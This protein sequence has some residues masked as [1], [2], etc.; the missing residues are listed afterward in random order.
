MHSVLFRIREPVQFWWLDQVKIDHKPHIKNKLYLEQLDVLERYACLQSYSKL[1]LM[2]E[3]SYC[4]F[5][6][7]VT[8][9]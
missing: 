4:V 8:N 1:R 3:S 2:R 7:T 9:I 5:H 6:L